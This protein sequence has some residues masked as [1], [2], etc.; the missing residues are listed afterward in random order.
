MAEF[1]FG[2]PVPGLW[3]CAFPLADRTLIGKSPLLRVPE[4]FLS[5]TTQNVCCEKGL[6]VFHRAGIFKVR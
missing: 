3:Y 1:Q 6:E 2:D 5:L 4:L